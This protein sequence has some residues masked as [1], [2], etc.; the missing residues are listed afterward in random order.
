[1]THAKNPA[2]VA[3]GKLAKGKSKTMTP[4]KLAA[5]RANGAKGGRPI[6]GWTVGKVAV[7]RE[8]KAS[9]GDIQVE[10]GIVTAIER[11]G[12]RMIAVTNAGHRIG[13][14]DGKAK[15]WTRG[16]PPKSTAQK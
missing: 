8:I 10:R 6:D 12:R 5:N 14:G 3:L 16:I 1:M 15:V 9:V 7:G 11:K 2:A 4:A 13:F